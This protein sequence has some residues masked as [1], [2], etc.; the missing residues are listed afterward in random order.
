M[1]PPTGIL[2]LAQGL[3]NMRMVIQSQCGH[4]FMVEHTE[5]FNRTSLDFLK[6]KAVN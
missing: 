5:L 2:K 1:M 3:K 6:E 4:W